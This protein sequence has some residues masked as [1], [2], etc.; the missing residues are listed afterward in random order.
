MHK[1]FC[2]YHLE[3]VWELDVFQALAFKKRA[4]SDAY[5]PLWQINLLEVS[6]TSECV[7][8]YFHQCTPVLEHNF[9]H[10][11]AFFKCAFLNFLDTLWDDNC[12]YPSL[13]ETTGHDPLQF[14]SWCEYHALQLLAAVER[15]RPDL[16]YAGWDLH[17]LD[18]NSPEPLVPDLFY[19][20]WD[21]H[22]LVDPEV[23]KL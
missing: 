23:P 10:I 15:V 16:L 20:F 6:A 22:L 5:E 13:V 2:S 7:L 17:T 14:T 8:L 9:P 18:V 1:T 19:A 4:A 11:L 21:Y 12:F 3:S